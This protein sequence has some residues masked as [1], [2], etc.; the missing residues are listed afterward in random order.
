MLVAVTLSLQGCFLDLASDNSFVIAVIEVVAAAV[1]IA[2]IP[3]GFG[4]VIL[5][6]M[7]LIA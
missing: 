6:A 5:L 3:M 7:A 4:I 2:T 1:G